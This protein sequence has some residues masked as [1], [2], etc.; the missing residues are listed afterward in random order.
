MRYRPVTALVAVLV[1]TLP[2]YARGAWQD[3]LAA[4][5]RVSHGCSVAY[6]TQVVERTVDGRQ[7]IFAKV[8]CEDGRVFDATRTG[9]LEPFDFKECQLAREPQTC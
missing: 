7:V 4:E 9:S 2:G 1:L 5:I 6:L 8:H 3:D